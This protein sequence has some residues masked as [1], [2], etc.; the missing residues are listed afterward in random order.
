MMETRGGA[1]RQESEGY[2]LFRNC[3]ERRHER[4]LP[5]GRREGFVIS[6]ALLTLELGDN[7]VAINADAGDE[8]HIVER[9]GSAVGLAWNAIGKQEQH[10]EKSEK[11][12][13]GKGAV[14][15]VDPRTHAVFIAQRL[16]KTSFSKKI[17]F[18]RKVKLLL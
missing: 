9:I 10:P 13:Y 14:Y 6:L 16:E 17:P 1:V 2:E 4:G 12:L 5:G 18:C 7:G 15:P 8:I 11:Q 3:L